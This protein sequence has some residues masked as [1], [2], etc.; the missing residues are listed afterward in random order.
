MNKAVGGN[1]V[2]LLPGHTLAGFGA[3]VGAHIMEARCRTGNKAA[4]HHGNT[5][6]GVVL[7]GER[8]RGLWAVPVK[9][10]SHDGLGE[11][12]IRQPVRPLAL[13]LEAADHSVA[14][15]R[16]LMPAHLVQ[17][18]IAVQNVADDQGHLDD[19]LPIL[20]SRNDLRLRDDGW[21]ILAEV[22]IKALFAVLAHPCQRLLIF[23]VVIDADGNT[24][25]NLDLIHPLGADAEIFLQNTRIA[26]AA[27][28]AHRH[29]ANIDVGFVL[30]PACGNSTAGETQNFLG[31][32]IGNRII[33]GFL[34]VM[35]VNGESRQT[36]LGVC[37]QNRSQIHRARTLGAV[38]APNCLNGVGVHVERL[39]TIAP[40]G[41]H[42]QCGRNILGRE[43][44]CHTG[45]LGTATNCRTAN[46]A[47]HRRTIGVLEVLRNQLGG[48][49]CHAHR[50]IFQAFTDTAPASINYR[51]NTN[52]RIQHSCTFLIIV[53]F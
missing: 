44:L 21:Q 15:Q 48:I 38:E 23:I 35:A 53:G 29:S 3:P 36:A 7:S 47:L 22:L 24:A 18:R 4:Q 1:A 27:R 9:G 2:R 12:S 28:N 52:F 25:Q 14:A 20:V 50:L 13:T 39:S 37:G 10:R 40:A 46:H 49:F 19:K 34:H 11:V 51:A 30:H 41:G 6:A 43:L 5:V 45:S 32:V 31:H 16:F 8:S 17:T 42:G 26:E 33:V